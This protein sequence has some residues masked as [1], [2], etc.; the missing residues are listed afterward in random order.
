[1]NSEVKKIRQRRQPVSTKAC[2]ESQPEDQRT[3]KSVIIHAVDTLAEVA[4][5]TPPPTPNN[6][7]MEQP[8][9]VPPRKRVKDESTGEAKVVKTP[10]KSKAKAPKKRA[11]A[12]KPAESKAKAAKVVAT[13]E[14][15]EAISEV[16]VENVMGDGEYTFM[17]EIPLI[18]EEITEYFIASDVN[19]GREELV[20]A[21]EWTDSIEEVKYGEIKIE[22]VLST[23]NNREFVKPVINIIDAKKLKVNAEVQTEDPV[24]VVKVDKA[25]QTDDFATY[26]HLTISETVRMEII[27]EISKQDEE[28]QTDL[29]QEDVKVDK[30]DQT[31]D[32]TIPVRKEIRPYEL[33]SVR[34]A[35]LVD[36]FI[37]YPRYQAIEV[38]GEAYW[39]IE[40]RR[41]FPTEW[42]LITSPYWDQFRAAADEE[43]LLNTKLF[44]SNYDG[45]SVWVQELN[46]FLYAIR[47]GFKVT[48]RY[49]NRGKGNRYQYKPLL[50]IEEK[51]P[52]TSLTNPTGVPVAFIPPDCPFW[53]HLFIKLTFPANHQGYSVTVNSSFD[54]AKYYVLVEANGQ[55]D[56]KR[57][58]L[59]YRLR[60]VRNEE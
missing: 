50:E 31:S 12:K 19:V 26:R 13:K 43:D 20:V 51:E 22:E 46:G 24:S 30:G 42:I 1:M 11:K 10:S 59:R 21:K 29:V 16:K 18:E 6:V 49:Q 53:H 55:V 56:V 38:V 27:P 36:I 47:H 28:S 54:N 3:M 57:D 44:I 32:A 2:S 58:G 14:D 48:I 25:T 35:R 45:A 33:Q 37:L 41:K 52:S 8:T 40:K 4:P 9:D 60:H 17:V 15:T 34:G 5:D 23:E 7:N 39:S